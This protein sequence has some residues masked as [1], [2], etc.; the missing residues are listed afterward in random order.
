MKRIA[1]RP[2]SEKRKRRFL[3]EGFGLTSTFAP[4]P[5][6][7]P[8]VA[9]GTSGGE[10]PEGSDRK[11]CSR[12]RPTPFLADPAAIIRERSQG[13]WCEIHLPG[14]C[15]G[16]GSQLSH[17]G[18]RQMGGRLGQARQLCDRPSN[19][20]WSCSRCHQVITEHPGRGYTYGWLLKR[21]M[22]PT[23]RWVLR[24]GAPVFLDDF[25][26]VHDYETAGA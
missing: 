13:G 21:H 16:Q 8:L 23:Q 25:G 3:A 19:A 15:L 9:T 26:G 14:E 22:E 10:V 24:R 17:R 5:R 1:I 6:R 11:R 12:G 4:R 18:G 2:M 20:L 7:T